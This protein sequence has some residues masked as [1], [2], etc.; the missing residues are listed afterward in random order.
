MDVLANHILLFVIL[1]LQQ[2]IFRRN[3]EIC[4]RGY[5]I[6][7]QET[8]GVG[9]LGLPD[10]CRPP[11]MFQVFVPD[12]LEKTNFDLKENDLGWYFYEA[13]KVWVIVGKFHQRPIIRVSAQIYNCDDDYHK[14]AAAVNHFCKSV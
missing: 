8:E 12:T 10:S 4:S 2:E 5:D 7:M 13:E 14:V 1:F 11:N 9:S 3:K 6:V